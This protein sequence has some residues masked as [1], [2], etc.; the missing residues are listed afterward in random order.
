M[1]ESDEPGPTAQRAERLFLQSGFVWQLCWSSFWTLF[2]LRVVVDVGLDPLQLLLLGTAKEITILTVEIPTG[3]VAD[4]RGRRLS[5]ILAFAI[6]GTAIAGAG[7]APGFISLVAT[8]VLWA[9]GSTFR[10][11]AEAAWL[12]DEVRSL[13]RV[14]VI[15]PRRGRTE[16][17][18][19]IVGL[20]ALSLLAAATG[21]SAALVVVGSIL[22]VWA[23]FLTLR[24]PETGFRRQA[25]SGRRRFR[26]LL[27]D[28]VRA[29]RRPGLRVLVIAAVLAGFASEA[30][31][32]L[33]VARLDEI[34]LQT[35][36]VD[37][38][39]LVGAAAVLTSVGA[40]LLLGVLAPLLRGPGLVPALTALHLATAAGVALL[41]RV[42]LLTVAVAGFIAQGTMRS[43]ARTVTIGWTNHFTEAA[44]RATVHSFV[45]QAGSLGE[46]SGGI[47]LGVLAQRVG[48]VA[49]LTASAAVYL[50]AATT[51][52]LGRRRWAAT[53]VAL[54]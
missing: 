27:S 16:A 17:V 31:D 51:A 8:Q 14:D 1:T 11:G 49:A 53:A 24:M 46:I 15:L 43:I 40:F 48:I 19:S 25:A 32:R 26:A 42:D 18:G 50:V 35:I 22:V 12:T 52:G 29:S 45:G 10:S 13:E 3:V 37:P 5:V 23:C 36:A 47:V 4:I 28:G 44:N 9:F 2:F 38:A 6:C 39:L 20:I 34:G 41:A 33:H 54:S 30:V 7:L 21:L